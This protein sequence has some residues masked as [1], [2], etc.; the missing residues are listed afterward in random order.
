MVLCAL[1]EPFMLLTGQLP[2]IAALAGEYMQVLLWAMVP[3]VAAGVLR[4]FVS[5]LGRPVLA[6]LITAAGIGVNALGNYTF[7]FGNFGAPALG[8]QGAAWATV[9]TSLVT[10]SAYVL[11]IRLVPGLHRYHVFGYFWR[12]DWPRF[13]ALL[14]IGTPIALT[15]TAEAGI[16]GTAAFLMG[17]IGAAE[18]AAHTVALQIAALAFQVPFGVSQAATIR[19]GYF[20]GARDAL[21]VTRAGWAAVVLGTGFMMLT[22]LL[23]I[24]A[25]ELLLRI[26]ID[27]HSGTNAALGALAI[28]YLTVASAFQLTDGIQVVAAGALRGLQDTRIPMWIAI[29][30]YWVPG[31]GLAAGLGLYTPLEGVGVWIGL[32][33]GLTFAAALLLLRWH[34]RGRLGLVAQ[35]P[36]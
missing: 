28:S 35:A 7:I 34:W 11:A 3:M 13:A 32:A 16:F 30:S 2:R 10:L 33:T 18:L 25:P 17:L 9:V 14:R 4:S 19:V 21:G 36:A 24:L 1:A 27:P 6:T 20:H 23:M 12:P 26:Y 5:T 8:L 15:V 31:F 29:F 22:A